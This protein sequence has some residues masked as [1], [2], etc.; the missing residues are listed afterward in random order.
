[1]VR[2]MWGGRRRRGVERR[3]HEMRPGEKSKA[4]SA[5]AKVV[6]KPSKSRRERKYLTERRG[7]G[8]E[9][10]R[11][12]RT[13]TGGRRSRVGRPP[14]LGFGAKRS[15]YRGRVENG[16][17]RGDGRYRERGGRGLLRGMIGAYGY[18][19]IVKRMRREE[20]RE[21]ESKRV[22]RKRKVKK[23]G[24]IRRGR[25]SRRRSRGWRNGE[26]VERRRERRGRE[27]RKLR[28]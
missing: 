9:N 21:A 20:G 17:V 6:A 27:V 23:E 12:A 2:R 13:R 7:R 25:G 11:M 26:G 15:V 4:V 28:V 24:A 19:R 8:K 5:E 22:R 1:M 18:L 10:G 16:R 14:R 3:G